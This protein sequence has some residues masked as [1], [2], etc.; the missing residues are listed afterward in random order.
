MKQ[1]YISSETA[2]PA[3]RQN[4]HNEHHALRRPEEN[5]EATSQ[6]IAHENGSIIHVSSIRRRF[7]AC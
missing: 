6:L 7:S 4:V 5:F 1:A 3:K 2:D